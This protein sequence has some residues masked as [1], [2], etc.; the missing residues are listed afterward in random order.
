MGKS[1]THFSN[2]TR[3]F[4]S[5]NSSCDKQC[6]HMCRGRFATVY[7]SGAIPARLISCVSVK[8]NQY[9]GPRLSCHWGP[10]GAVWLTGASTMFGL[11]FLR[12]FTAWKTSTT[13]C[14]FTISTT[15]PM[16]QN[17]PLRPP[18]FLKAQIRCEHLQGT[19]TSHHHIYLGKE[20]HLYYFFHALGL[21]FRFVHAHVKGREEGNRR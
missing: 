19:R 10:P 12:V 8:S 16:A 1:P 15:M 2:W 5:F 4:P 9:I 7:L 17:M 11:L 3:V 6:V 20:I 13:F 18:P 21:W 14:R